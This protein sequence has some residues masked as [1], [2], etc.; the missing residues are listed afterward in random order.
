MALGFLLLPVER[1]DFAPLVQQ[2]GIM[3][4][5]LVRAYKSTGLVALNAPED[6][7]I[8]GALHA[9][10]AG[11]RQRWIPALA[12]GWCLGRGEGFLGRVGGLVQAASA[13]EFVRDSA[14]VLVGWCALGAIWLAV[15]SVGLD[16][17]VT[18]AHAAAANSD[19]AHKV[20]GEM[21]PI[22]GAAGSLLSQALGKMAATLGSICFA[23]AGIASLWTGGVLLVEYTTTPDTAAQRY[24]PWLF[25]IRAAVALGLLYPLNSGWGGGQQ[26]VSW[27]GAW[28]SDKASEA[29]TQATGYLGDKTQWVNQP[30]VPENEVLAAVLQTASAEACAAA[31]NADPARSENE[32]VV[33]EKTS[34]GGRY[35]YQ[36]NHL[37]IWTTEVAGGC[38][39]VDYA[40]PDGSLGVAAK[41]VATSHAAAFEAMR[42]SVS[43]EV[44]AFVKGRVVCRDHP[45]ACKSD[46]SP[47]A[48]AAIPNAYRT[49][50]ETGLKSNWATINSAASAKLSKVS[51]DKGWL[52]AGEWAQTLSQ[53]QASM[54][55]AAHSMPRVAPP[56]IGSAQEVVGAVHQWAGNGLM[57]AGNSVIRAEVGLASGMQGAED[58]LLAA[59]GTGLWKAVA[60]VDQT[61][62][63]ASLSTTGQAV[64]MTGAGIL[65]VS[66][67]V[68]GAMKGI[69]GGADG[70]NVGL[71]G[72]VVGYAGKFASKM[73]IVSAV[74]GAVGGAIKP[75]V[76]GAAL[77]CIVSGLGLAY[78]VPALPFIRFYFS[79]VGWLIAFVEAVM[80]VP[81]ALVLLVTAETG[82]FFG[83]AAKAGL[84]N[85]VA[86]ALR[87]FLALAGFVAGLLLITASIGLLNA[88]MLPAIRDIMQGEAMLLAFVA[89]VLVYLTL[90]YVAVNTCTKAA[91]LLPA[92]GY[93]W[94]GANAGGERD[95]GAAVTSAIGSISTRVMTEIGMRARAGGRGPKT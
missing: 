3:G 32:R 70:E 36:L 80:L 45:N 5:A 6:V 27:F 52:G 25:A 88:L 71:V 87:P 65:A 39:T 61:N 55:A 76:N 12:A 69:A 50:I 30:G 26:L 40:A 58:G 68:E 21:L 14:A 46:P 9:A 72:T 38:G 85:V 63:L 20:L 33:Y 13:K 49:A 77:A 19:L 1:R 44:I 75:I 66:G 64:W 41:P 31:I 22:G 74:I 28:G 4:R 93:R 54:G 23:F 10:G 18:A 79:V 24:T 67:A 43:A 15:A 7:G 82:G 84:W 29:W 95:D 48:L 62:A 78:V 35:D 53:F 86:L 89:Y 8:R 47:A 57:A 92:A 16:L 2:W 81:V 42:K 59:V 51:S 73:P 94:L 91:E 90:A 60:E 83:S 37:L 34:R 56:S 17:T 11:W